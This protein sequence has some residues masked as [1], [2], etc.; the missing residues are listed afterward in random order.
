MRAPASAPSPSE[1]HTAYQA[2]STAE[3]TDTRSYEP[4]AGTCLHERTGRT[5]ASAYTH[6]RRWKVK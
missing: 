4:D 1:V 5:A 2:R 3:P 6:A